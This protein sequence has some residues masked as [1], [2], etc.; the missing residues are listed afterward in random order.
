MTS[1]GSTTRARTI[2]SAS[3]RTKRLIS[4]ISARC[5]VDFANGTA[6]GGD[7]TGPVQIVCRGTAIPH[8]IIVDVENAVGSYQDHHLIG[9]DGV[10]ELSGGAGNDILTGGLGRD[11]LNVGAGSDTADYSADDF[12]IV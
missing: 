5:T 9:S 4:I 8:D 3:A 10:N 7:A 6:S 11:L 1:G 2:P 12:F